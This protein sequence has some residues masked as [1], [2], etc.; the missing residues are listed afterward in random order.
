[1]YLIETFFINLGS[2]V[3][4]SVSNNW[5]PIHESVKS[6]DLEIVKFLIEHK[7][8]VNVTVPG[9]TGLDFFNLVFFM[10]FLFK[11]ILS[12]S[13]R[14]RIYGLYTERKNIIIYIIYVF[15]L[16]IVKWLRSYIILFITTFINVMSWQFNISISKFIFPL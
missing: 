3:F 15:Q 7:A 1:M 6:G 2:Q 5:Q 8:E 10:K 13:I 14:S 4:Y 9:L 11:I 16:C 12:S